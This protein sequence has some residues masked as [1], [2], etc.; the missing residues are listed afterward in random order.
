MH[1]KSYTYISPSYVNYRINGTGRD[2][3][4]SANNGGYYRVNSMI[5]KP[6]PCRNSY[7]RP[8]TPSTPAPRSVKYISDGTG[9]DRYIG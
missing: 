1:P 7:I 9:R 4:I 5:N 2:T 6:N 3:Y 8:V